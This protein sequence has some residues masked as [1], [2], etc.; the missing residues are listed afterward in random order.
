MDQQIQEINQPDYKKIFIDIIIK[1]FPEKITNCETILQKQKL[2][3]L[4]ILKLN[5]IIFGHFEKMQENQKYRSYN[6]RTI[7]S[8]L[9]YQ[10]KNNLNNTE[11]AR[12]YKISRNT[13]TKWKR[14]F[15]L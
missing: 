12:H 7:L 5:S 14:Y 1:K 11:L 6:K 8:I 15:I 3:G 10:R 13:I 4:D 9:D 2:S